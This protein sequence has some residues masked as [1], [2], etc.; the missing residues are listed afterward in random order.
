MKRTTCE[1]Q[2]KQQ[3]FFWIASAILTPLL[4]RT[5]FNHTLLVYG[6][7]LDYPEQNG[8]ELPCVVLM[9][10][11]STTFDLFQ[12]SHSCLIVDLNVL[13][14]YTQ[15]I[16]RSITEQRFKTSQ[17]SLTYKAENISDCWDADD[18]N[19]VESQ[20]AGGDEDVPDPAELSPGKQQ[21]G[22]RRANLKMITLQV[23]TLASPWPKKWFT[24][25]KKTNKQNPNQIS[26]QTYYTL[27]KSDT[28][29][30]V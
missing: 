14:I 11:I 18:E 16:S 2:D 28:Y 27:W 3:L 26:S 20:D 6:V 15:S 5:R 8:C 29:P 23:I 24:V 1:D 30:S 19:V 10:W 17:T 25:I 13:W 4:E 22:D 7:M 9:Q 21:R 12:R